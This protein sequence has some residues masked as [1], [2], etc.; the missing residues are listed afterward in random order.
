M[1]FSFTLTGWNEYG[2]IIIVVRFKVEMSR[3]GIERQ[4][5]TNLFF[6]F[7]YLYDNS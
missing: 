5:Q 3:N 6:V 2:T 4:N 7:I 1:S